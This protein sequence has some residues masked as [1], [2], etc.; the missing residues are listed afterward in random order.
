MAIKWSVQEEWE[1]TVLFYR[2]E[3]DSELREI[4]RNVCDGVGAQSNRASIFLIW[5][6]S[7]LVEFGHHVQYETESQDWFD[8]DYIKLGQK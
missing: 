8:E 3:D 4:V 7:F 5:V 2:V 6:D 1:R